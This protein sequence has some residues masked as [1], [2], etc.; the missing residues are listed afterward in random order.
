MEDGPF[1]ERPYNADEL[2]DTLIVYDRGSIL[3]MAYTASEA[4]VRFWRIV[5]SSIAGGMPGIAPVVR[6]FLRTVELARLVSAVTYLV[7]GP[8]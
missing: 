4:D 7:P 1:V 5:P 2:P 6:V 3:G 8:T